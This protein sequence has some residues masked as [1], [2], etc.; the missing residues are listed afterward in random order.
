M[1]NLLT[2]FASIGAAVLEII[3]IGLI[4]LSTLYS[5]VRG[6]YKWFIYPNEPNLFAEVREYFA[7][8]ILLGLEVLIAADIIHTVAVQLTL[9]SLGILAIVILIRTFLSFTLEVETTGKW[10]WNRKFS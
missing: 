8:G 3:G 9:N 10:P 7:R 1:G 2:V 4:F 6:I 5:I